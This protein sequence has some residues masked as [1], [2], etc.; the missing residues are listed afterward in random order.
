MSQRNDFSC[1]KREEEGVWGISTIKDWQAAGS[2][3]EGR[4][5]AAGVGTYHHWMEVIYLES[6]NKRREEIKWIVAILVIV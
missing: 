6:N 2:K 5:L 1:P 4:P 3:L